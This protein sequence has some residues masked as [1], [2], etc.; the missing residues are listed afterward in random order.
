MKKG[1]IFFY[2]LFILALASCGFLPKEEPE[3]DAKLKD[4]TIWVYEK[5]NSKTQKE[6]LNSLK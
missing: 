4:D 6:M 3:E 1:F 2:S 5:L